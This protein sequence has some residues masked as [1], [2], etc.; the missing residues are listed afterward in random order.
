MIRGRQIDKL[1]CESV[2][3]YIV[4][5]KKKKKRKG[6]EANKKAHTRN[7]TKTKRN[8]KIEKANILR[9]RVKREN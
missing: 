6:K 3:A 2:D 7:Q 5:Y 1:R 8:R 4:V 9:E